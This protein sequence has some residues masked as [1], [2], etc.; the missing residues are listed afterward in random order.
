[1]RVDL[2]THL[3]GLDAR[4]GCYTSRRM[5]RGLTFHFL[6]FHL[7]LRGVRSDAA[8]GG[9][10]AEIL[11]RWVRESG[12]I[13]RAV[14]YAMDGVYDASGALDLG[15]THHMV[16]NDYLF[17]VCRAHPELLPGA[18]VNPA[19]RD[20]LDELDRVAALG[21]VLVK[22]LPNSQL[23]DPGDRAHRGFFRRCAELR[24]PVVCHTGYEHTLP[25]PCQAYGDPRRL[26]PA[27]EEGATVIAA[28]AGASGVLDE[29]EYFDDFLE[30]CDRYDRLYGDTAALCTPTRR[31]YLLRLVEMPAVCARLVHGSDF[32]IPVVPWL[33][34]D[35]VTPPA[36]LRFVRE[37]NPLT[38]DVLMKRAVGL[39]E[40]ILERG[41]RL[42]G[43]GHPLEE[44]KA[45]ADPCGAAPLFRRDD[46][47]A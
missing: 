27:L 33:L 12:E 14:V 19:R 2:H 13:D 43:L 22:L 29:I 26:V 45:G 1:M 40:D 20:A 42:L 32:P 5:R 24:L 44:R 41:A 18:S 28:H 6:K 38:R 30:L 8:V 23:F 21:A 4:A 37:K 10:Y 46:E 25:A 7:G 35:E 3:I 39:P 16:G 17:S 36:T 9:A 47:E 11:A 31:R 34:A 15:R